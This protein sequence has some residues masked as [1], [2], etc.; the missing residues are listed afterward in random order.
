[1]AEHDQGGADP[2]DVL[3]LLRRRGWLLLAC[4][5]VLPVGVYLY[6]DRLEKVYEASVQLQVQNTAADDPI[7]LGSA[8][9]SS[10]SNTTVNT[11]AALIGTSGVADEVARVLG[12][13]KG[14][15]SGTASA[16]EASGFITVTVSASS[17]ERAARVANAYGEAV[18]SLRTRQAEQKVDFAIARLRKDL[19]A[20]RGS[21]VARD[22]LSEQLQQLRTLRAAQ[23]GNTRVVEPAAVPSTAVSP[24]PRRNAVLAILIALLLG[25][26]LMLLAD[27]LDRRLRTVEDVERHAGVPLLATITADAFPGGRPGPHVSESFQRLRDNLTYFNADEELD[28]LMVVSPLQG[29]GKT[30]VAMNLAIAFARSGKRV[31]LID[32]DLRRP[33]VAQR[34]GVEAKTGLSSVLTGAS[35]ESGLHSVDPYGNALR[36]MPAGPSAPNPSE[37]LGSARM[38]KLLDELSELADVVVIDTTPL[39][40]VS[41]AIPLLGKVSGCIALARLNSTPHDALDR[42]LGIARSAGGRVLGVVATGST[43]PTPYGYGYDYAGD[44]ETSPNG[45]NGS[46]AA[47]L[48]LPD[49]LRR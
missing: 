4:L 36:V 39:M 31:I 33:K 46:T 22:Q 8:F 43:A 24:N 37:L 28:T 26:G 1:M 13:P 18:G 38:A 32:G 47:G 49:W 9:S 35:V 16:D 14:S 29:E 15:V 20:S 5:I 44:T 30:T 48:R 41:D 45:S 42:T 27:R 10:S 23:A 3:T 17:G 6:S 2:R 7:Q 19:A 12:E 40:I 11:I 34:M 21:Q 25:I